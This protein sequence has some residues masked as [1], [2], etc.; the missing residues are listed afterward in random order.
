MIESEARG[1]ARWIFIANPRVVNAVGIEDLERLR[2]EVAMA[3]R[4]PAAALIVL[5]GRSGNFCAGDNLKESR[6]MDR[7]TFRS[8]IAAFQELSWTV[9]RATK[10]IA[11]FVEG[12][13]LG[14]GAEI[15]L[16][17]DFVVAERSAVVG[18]PEV[19]LGGMISNA[20]SAFLG[21]TLGLPRASELVLLSQRRRADDPALASLFTFVGDH[22]DCIGWLDRAAKQLASSP[23]AAVARSREALRAPG[24]PAR[25]SALTEE[26]MHAMELFELPAY[27]AATA[28]FAKKRA[29]KGGQDDGSA[30][31]PDR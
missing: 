14:G 23:P 13:A 11:A 18:C 22:D 31:H 27:K 25:M 20:S 4:D 29:R 30:A 7:V 12:Y 5:A 24:R 6:V 17:C 15:A 21:E 8:L 26:L 16:M 10:P 3:L 9:E 28:V 2:E 19:G 1:A